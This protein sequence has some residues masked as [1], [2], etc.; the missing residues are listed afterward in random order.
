MSEEKPTIMLEMRKLFTSDLSVEVPLA[1]EIFQEE[2][3][4]EVT[5]NV[6]H[7]VKELPPENYYEIKLR[8]AVT[9]KDGDKTIYIVDVSQSGIFEIQG[10]EQQ[11]LHHA[12]NVYCPNALYPYAREI[13]STSIVRAGFPSL[14]LQPV[15]FEALYQQQMQQAA[16]EQEAQ[17][18]NKDDAN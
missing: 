16:Q 3:N 17:A 7:E 8:L 18:P 5:F 1:P 15:N 9:A 13:I 12:I 14:Y 2:L 11:Q 4:P 10:L 6:G